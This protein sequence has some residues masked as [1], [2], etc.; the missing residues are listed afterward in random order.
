MLENY[1]IAAPFDNIQ[2]IPNNACYSRAL[3]NITR[4][5]LLIKQISNFCHTLPICF[6]LFNLIFRIVA[7]WK[8]IVRTTINDNS[9]NSILLKI[10]RSRSP[11]HLLHPA[12]PAGRIALVTTSDTTPAPHS[13]SETAAGANKDTPAASHSPYPAA[14]PAPSRGS[15]QLPPNSASTA[16]HSSHRK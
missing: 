16:P 4:K 11:R 12:S 9:V 3:K 5:Q 2:V 14:S 1:K 6:A 10:I 15:N 7:Q 8:N 13:T